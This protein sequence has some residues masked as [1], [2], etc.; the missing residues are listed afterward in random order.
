MKKGLISKGIKPFLN[1]D[2]RE[3][4]RKEGLKNQLLSIIKKAYI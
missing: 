4:Y 3:V 1:Y 2:R